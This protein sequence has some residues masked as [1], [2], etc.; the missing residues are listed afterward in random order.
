MIAVIGVAL[1]VVGLIVGCI[2]AA[3]YLASLLGDE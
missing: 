3:L 1:I 2:G